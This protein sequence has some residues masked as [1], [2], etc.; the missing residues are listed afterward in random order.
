MSNDKKTIIILGA[1]T[2]VILLLSGVAEL[3][4]PKEVLAV[5]PEITEEIVQPIIEEG[6]ELIEEVIPEDD[7]TPESLTGL[8]IGFDESGGLTDVMML[9]VLDT[10]TNQVKV[11]SIPRDMYIDFR[12]EKYA[13]IKENN[14]E[15]WVWACKLNEVYS[16]SG[17]ND[18]ALLDVKEIISIVTGVEID[19]MA[20]ID[21]EGFVDV[22][23]AV[24]GVDFYVPEDMNY[25]DPAADFLID[26]DE[27]QQVLDGS[28][29]LQLV[30]YR[31]YEWGDLQRIQVQQDFMFSTYNE[32]IND[33]SF[34]EII[35]LVKIAYDI[36]DTDFGLF[37]VLK[38]VE[39]V[40]NLDTENILSPENM[41]TVP[42]TSEKIDGLWY[43][44]LDEEKNKEMID[45][46]F[47]DETEAV[48]E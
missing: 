39:Y 2:A 32:V 10:E 25:Y 44:H 24:G 19:Y 38:Y 31:N 16:Y 43:Q 40:F 36:V 37:D 23:D 45:N 9:G 1:I 6:T 46:L 41:V 3:F 48:V 7:P 4:D 29:A 22:V 21:V 15:N 18:R 14:P 20:T 12:T 17:W 30:R 27:G 33:L 8:V 11:I 35:D 47:E 28:K 5:V 34:G 42:T 26:L 13:H